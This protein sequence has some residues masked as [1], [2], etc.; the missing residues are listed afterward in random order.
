MVCYGEHFVLPTTF[1]IHDE[2]IFYIT[3]SQLDNFNQ[4]SNEIKNIDKPE[5]YELMRKKLE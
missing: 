5:P 3:N 2:H 4:E 1:T